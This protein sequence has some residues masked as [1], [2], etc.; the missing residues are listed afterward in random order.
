MAPQLFLCIY[1]AWGERYSGWVKQKYCTYSICQ[2]EKAP[3]NYHCMTM[4]VSADCSWRSD[5]LAWHCYSVRA[6]VDQVSIKE[7]VSRDFCFWFFSWISFLPA[8]E[9]PIRTVSNFFRKFAETF[10]SQGASPVQRHRWQICKCES[11]TCKLRGLNVSFS[12]WC[13]L[14]LFA[15]FH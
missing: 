3:Q 2:P 9:Y 13:N 6:T 1:W 12:H 7:T 14:L 15:T 10:A 11:V 5:M 8:P 4:C